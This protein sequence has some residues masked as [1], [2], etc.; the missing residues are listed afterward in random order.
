MPREQ[1]RVE[2]RGKGECVVE[3]DRP[4]Y[5]RVRPNLG[6]ERIH[7]VP[8][9]SNSIEVWQALRDAWSESVIF[10][11]SDPEAALTAAAEEINDLVAQG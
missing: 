2:K 11:E 3:C 8:N 4:L 7:E 10:G 6:A 1:P 5:G 9:V